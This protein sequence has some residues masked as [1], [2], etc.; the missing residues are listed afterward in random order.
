L[1]LND[2]IGVLCCF[3]KQQKRAHLCEPYHGNFSLATIFLTSRATRIAGDD[4]GDSILLTEDVIHN[5]STISATGSSTT[6]C[7]SNDTLDVWHSYTASGNSTATFSLCGSGFDTSLAVFDS[8]G[9]SE[10]ACNDDFCGVQSEVTLNVQSG[11]T[12]FVRVAG[13]EGATGN[14]NLLVTETHP[15]NDECVDAI[16]ATPGVAYVGTSEN[17][18]GTDMTT[19]GTNDTADVWLSYTASVT[20]VVA[21]NLCGS[22]FDTTLAVFDSCGGSELVCNDDSCGSQSKVNLAVNNGITYYIRIAG[23]NGATGDYTLNI[24]E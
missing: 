24:I 14:Y 3:W 12:Y 9:G 6:T 22:T 19:C 1:A 20:A 21:I 23:N 11:V 15:A 4:C 10:L 8:C 13:F 18:G 16:A 5:G 17:A 7:S 2:E